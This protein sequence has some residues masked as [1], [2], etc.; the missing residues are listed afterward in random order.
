LSPPHGAAR[1]IPMESFA[2]SLDRRAGVNQ[3]AMLL[4]LI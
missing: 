2:S 4:N 1:S 3:A